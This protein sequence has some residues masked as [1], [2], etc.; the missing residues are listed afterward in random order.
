MSRRHTFVQPPKGYER[1]LRIA[2]LL[3]NDLVEIL[4]R[5][6]RDPRVNTAHLCVEEVRVNKD[7]S[8][9]DIFFTSLN[10]DGPETQK[11]LEGILNNAK[12]FL[13]SEL[14]QVNYFRTMPELFFRYDKT[15][16]T[17]GRMDKLI[18]SAM[19]RE[20]NGT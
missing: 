9:A 5:K 1:E 14:A 16:E 17:A 2:Q 10:A 15:R 13:R 7:L 3:R 18:A 8:R 20:D 12:G 4:S 6:F 11:E 19:Q